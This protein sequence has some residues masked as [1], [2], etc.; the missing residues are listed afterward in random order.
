MIPSTNPACMSVL[1][2]S[3]L[4]SVEHLPTGAVA[5]PCDRA[6]EVATGELAGPVEHAV[7]RDRAVPQAERAQRLDEAERRRVGP[8]LVHHVAEQAKAVADAERGAVLDLGL[9]ARDVVTP[10]RLVAPVH[11]GGAD[12][13]VHVT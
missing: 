5:M 11:L 4:E 9:H 12:A 8:H 1:S 10:E 13:G 2:E 3:G 6:V 7:P